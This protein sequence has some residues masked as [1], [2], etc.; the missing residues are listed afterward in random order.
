[1]K[2]TRILIFIF[3]FLIFISSVYAVVIFQNS[4]WLI[5]YNQDTEK[6]EIWEKQLEFTEEQAIEKWNNLQIEKQELLQ[7]YNESQVILPVCIDECESFQNDEI[8]SCE[9]E[10][11]YVFET[12]KEN[13]LERYN[14]VIEEIERMKKIKDAITN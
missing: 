3:V 12:E 10:C 9:E 7:T 1:M 2:R 4:N 6:Y 5:N 13:L 8:L 11:Q 14:K